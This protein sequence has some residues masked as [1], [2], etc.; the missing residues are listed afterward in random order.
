MGSQG[1]GL[2]DER[3][4]LEEG[5]QQ[6]RAGQAQISMFTEAAVVGE[7]GCRDG[8]QAAEG[9][10]RCGRPFSSARSGGGRGGT[11]S[12]PVG[13]AAVV[14]SSAG[15]VCPQPA[16]L[17]LHLLGHHQQHLTQALSQCGCQEGPGWRNGETEAQGAPGEGV[18]CRAP[19]PGLPPPHL[20]PSSSPRASGAR[21]LESRL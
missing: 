9:S 14:P 12:A 18:W 21:S 7:Q 17:L 20:T 5:A 10:M 16:P 2:S 8:G 13:R 19:A 1:T 4:S 6:T 3:E 11:G 15:S